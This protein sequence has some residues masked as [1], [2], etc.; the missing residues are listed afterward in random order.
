MKKRPIYLHEVIY[1]SAFIALIYGFTLVAEKLTITSYYPSPYGAYKE[2]RSTG[3]SYFAT[4]SG[5]Q[6][7]IGTTAPGAN[8]KLDIAGTEAVGI[9]YAKS[10][11]QDARIMLGDPGKH[12]S[13]AVGWATQ[14]DF[15][16]IEEGAAGDR[17]YIQQGGNTGIGTSNPGTKLDVVGGTVRGGGSSVTNEY[18]EIGHGGSHGYINTVGDGRLD[19]RHD[20]ATKMSL[21][22]GETLNVSAIKLGAASPITTWPS[23][24]R[25]F[26]LTS[27]PGCTASCSVTAAPAGYPYIWDD[28]CILSN[29]CCYKRVCMWTN[30][31]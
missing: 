30:T 19:F 22:S 14:G 1:F 5:S 13:M 4:T 23:G 2:L 29:G 18:T 27:P 16:I 3:N 12:W 28:E 10:G 17:L 9:R 21:E 7:G 25:L 11:S 24:G 31:P 15:S 8:T 20:G 26:M 6:V